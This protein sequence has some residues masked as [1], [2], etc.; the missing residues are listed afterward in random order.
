MNNKV[1][2]KWGQLQSDTPMTFSNLQHQ[3]TQTATVPGWHYGVQ[4]LDMMHFLKL[5]S[6]YGQSTGQVDAAQGC[7]H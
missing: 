6:K 5:L 4:N 1:S 3:T 7:A 2:A